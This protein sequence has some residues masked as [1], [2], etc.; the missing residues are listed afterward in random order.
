MIF[1]IGVVGKIF[2]VVWVELRFLAYSLFDLCSYV[3]EIDS[4]V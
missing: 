1:L 2:S 4:S 3:Q